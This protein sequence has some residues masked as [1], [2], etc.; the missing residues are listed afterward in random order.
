MPLRHRC[1]IAG[2]LLLPA[3]SLAQ[4]SMPQTLSSVAQQAILGNPEVLQ[5]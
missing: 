3:M 1:W 4:P 2:F 5:R